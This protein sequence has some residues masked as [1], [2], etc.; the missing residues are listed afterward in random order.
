MIPLGMFGSDQVTLTLVEESAT[1]TIPRGV[2]GAKM[3][4]NRMCFRVDSSNKGKH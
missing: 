4:E 1:A 3:E 2:E